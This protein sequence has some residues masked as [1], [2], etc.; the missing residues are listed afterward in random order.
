MLVDENPLW[1]IGSIYS[2]T[3]H[4]LLVHGNCICS[5]CAFSIVCAK[6][7][8][9]RVPYEKMLYARCYITALETFKL[10]ELPFK[11]SN[12]LH[13]I[14]LFAYIHAE[15]TNVTECKPHWLGWLWRGC[16]L[17][18]H[19]SQ[20]HIIWNPVDSHH[21]SCQVKCHQ[22]GWGNSTRMWKLSTN[23]NWC[24]LNLLFCFYANILY[25]PIVFLQLFL[26]FLCQH[27]L[28]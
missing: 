16:S 19:G 28:L 13:T 4:S 2:L 22:C 5:H 20:A 14:T 10:S 25:L 18:T 9:L 8:P 1:L 23:F 21:I 17:K 11:M 7:V 26:N 24:V 12:R 6:S 27:S 3:V 15:F